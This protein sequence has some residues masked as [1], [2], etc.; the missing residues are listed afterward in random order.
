MMTRVL[1]ID[2]LACGSLPLM[3]SS[4]PSERLSPASSGVGVNIAKAYQ[5]T[6][7]ICGIQGYLQGNQD[8]K[9]P[10]FPEFKS[11]FGTVRPCDGVGPPRPGCGNRWRRSVSPC[12]ARISEAAWRSGSDRK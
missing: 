2:G 3:G 11:S 9:A 7:G 4:L 12:A 6:S 10:G 8:A 1:A 5:G